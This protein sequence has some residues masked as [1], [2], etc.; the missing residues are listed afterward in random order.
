MRQPEG[1]TTTRRR[2]APGRVAAVSCAALALALGT[3]VGGVAQAGTSKYHL[4][5]PATRGEKDVLGALFLAF[6]QH[7]HA[8]SASAHVAFVKRYYFVGTTGKTQAGPLLRNPLIV[9]AQGRPWYAYGFFELTGHSRLSDQVSMQDGGNVAIF[10]AS[11]RWHVVEVGGSDRMCLASQLD[12]V[13]PSA[14]VA[15]WLQNKCGGG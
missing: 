5:G 4:Q 1:T 10:E 6:D 14:V 3:L 15:I 11:P 8:L 12:K 9:I 7:T 13:A 2:R